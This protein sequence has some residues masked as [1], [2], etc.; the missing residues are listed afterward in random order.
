MS[1]EAAPPLHRAPNLELRRARLRQPSPRVPGRRMS[2]QE[3]AE[4]VNAHLIAA[5]G[6]RVQID[7]GYIGRLERGTHRWPQADYRAGLRVVL[8]AVADS[9]IGFYSARRNAS[10]EKFLAS[11]P[12]FNGGRS[13]SQSTASDIEAG[14]K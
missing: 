7:A 4:A 2:R 12:A 3:L 8:G 14:R 11:D 5:I 1:D 13:D 9:E 10:D 6:R